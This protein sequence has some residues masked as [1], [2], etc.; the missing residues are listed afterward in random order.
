MEKKQNKVAEFVKNHKK[1]IAIL[2]TCSAALGCGIAYIMVDRKFRTP[3]KF[4]GV[5]GTPAARDISID[6]WSLGTLVEC[7]HER[8]W[9]NAIVTDFT[10]A[11]AGKLG[12]EL[13]KIDGIT[14][15]TALEAVLSISDG[16]VD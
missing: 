14:M 11:D 15:D 6:G 16:K 12:E 1:K 4:W 8:G 13:L 9:F 2:V 5:M 3:V 7:W 10:V